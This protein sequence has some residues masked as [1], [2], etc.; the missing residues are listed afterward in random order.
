MKKKQIRNWLI[1]F[2]LTVILTSFTLQNNNN[3]NYFNI[4]T[5]QVNHQNT[6]IPF[7]DDELCSIHNSS[8]KDGEELTYKAYYN[9]N[10]V[11]I[12]A[13]EVTFKVIDQGD[14][15]YINAKG[16]TYNSYDVFFKVRDEFKVW[17][18][19]KTMLPTTSVREVREGGYQLYDMMKYDFDKMEIR[20]YRGKDKD[21]THQLIYDIDNCMH[22]VLSIIYFIR[23]KDYDK[24]KKGTD[25]PIRIFLDKEKYSLKAKYVGK[26]TKEIKDLGTYKTV[27]LMPEV[28]SGEVFTDHGGMT[29]WATDDDNHLPLQIESPLSVGSIKAVL[30]SH[31]NLRYPVSS[32]VD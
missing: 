20:S 4:N 12:A 10:F 22:D 15:Y 28:I 3:N 24:M 7:A 16:R 1:L 32:K 5:N 27:K 29:I 17:V 23:N 18:D 31:K 25:I 26:E 21:N 13:G 14:K 11:W 8:F 9:W 19:K 30:K 6:A 2:G